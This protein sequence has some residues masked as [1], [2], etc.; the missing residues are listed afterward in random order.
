MRRL[1]GQAL[2]IGV[3]GS[4]VSLLRTSRWRAAGPALAVL[5]EHAFAPA[6]EHPF[7][8]IG[9]ALR[10]L[11]GEQQLAGWP[12]CIVLDDELTRLWQVTPPAGAARLADIEAAAGLRFH[13]LY[14]EAPAAWR[15]A[16]DWD[17]SHPF[18]AAAVP[19]TLLKVLEQVAQEHRLAIVAVTPHFVAAWN[20]WQRA[21]SPGAWFGVLHDG[22]LT[23]AAVEGKRLRAVRALPVP[24]GA[25]HY[26]LTQ[27]LTREALLHHLDVP[28]LL[29]L[30]GPAPA[31]WTGPVSNP[32]HIRC[33][34]LDLA[35]RAGDAAWS[36][37]AT[38]ARCGSPV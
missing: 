24:A 31:L 8:A 33:A 6:G 20:R 10:A 2:R 28:P 14:G 13:T 37:A 22:L 36:S 16:A 7:D 17:A 9:N 12:T 19:R 38:L 29:Q 15:I 27:T 26:W 21:L 5:A 23:V 34:A 35:Q 3:S 11:L 32:A 4:A 1:P 25:D 30:C 18:F